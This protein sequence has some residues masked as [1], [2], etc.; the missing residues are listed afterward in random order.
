M[1]FAKPGGVIAATAEPLQP[2]YPRR[3]WPISYRSVSGIALGADVCTIILCGVATGV[4]YNLEEFGTADVIPQY[5]ASAAVVAAFYVSVMK[6]YD[7]YNPSELLSLRTQV[8][9]AAT[10][11]LGVFLFLSG[12]VFALK[13]GSQFSRGAIFAFASTGLALL[14]V[15]RIL[16]RALLIRGLDRQRFSGRNVILISDDSIVAETQLAPALLKHG[17]QL[18]HQFAI[19]SDE[20]NAKQQENLIA[21][22]IAYLRGSPID[23]VI[24]SVD[25]K[26]WDDLTKLLSGLRTLPLPVHLIPVGPAADIL[27]R[28]SHVMGDSI[29]IELQREPLGAFERGIK[30]SIDIFGAVTGLILLLPLLTLTAALIK[31]D[32]KGPV[33]FRQK[34]C[35]F[36][37]RP[38]YI[39]KFRTMSVLEDGPAVCQAEPSDYRLTRLGKWLR[40][41]SIDELPQLV[42]VLFGSM[43]LVG[44]RPHAVAHDNHFDK[45]VSKYAFRHHV[46][47][48]LTGWAQVKGHRGPTPTLAD[49]RSRVECDLWYID[50]WSLRLDFLIIVRTIF[51]LMRARNAY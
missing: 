7:L 23:E 46:K 1:N 16:Y 22:V 47:P 33:L 4:L 44:P 9:S 15:Q 12:A 13:I 28:P 2:V 41:T 24:V 19:P 27:R 21:E 45:M 49:I 10:T 48:G 34:R 39:F 31:L 11:W 8:S 6:G 37:G 35:G 43:S 42:N 3:K 36:N 26:R 51:E 25:V 14:I 30:R 5:F 32:S 20:Q 17:F 38:F 29:Y 40:R 18:H 50:N